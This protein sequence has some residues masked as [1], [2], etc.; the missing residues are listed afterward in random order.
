M[1][2]HRYNQTVAAAVVM[3]IN[4]DSFYNCDLGTVDDD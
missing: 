1:I 3:A 2:S 4:A